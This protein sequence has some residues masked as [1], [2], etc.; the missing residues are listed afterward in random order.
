MF[1]AKLPG[2]REGIFPSSNQA[3]PCPPTTHGGGYT[4]SFFNAERQVGKAVN[5]NFWSLWLDST[6]IKSFQ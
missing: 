3:A 6:G 1:F 4:L 2:D 5:T